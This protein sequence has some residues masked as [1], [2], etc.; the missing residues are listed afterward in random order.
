MDPVKIVRRIAWFVAKSILLPALAL[1]LV[2][3]MVAG[4]EARV[5]LNPS[6]KAVSQQLSAKQTLPEGTKLAAGN[7]KNPVTITY[8]HGRFALGLPKGEA[9]HTTM[10]R[11]LGVLL[12]FAHSQGLN[13][14]QAPE[15]AKDKP[16]K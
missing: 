7:P 3:G 1:A 11:G 6:L 9:M 16:A 2:V 14:A 5:T 10:L 4:P 13:I 12:D 8:S 15:P